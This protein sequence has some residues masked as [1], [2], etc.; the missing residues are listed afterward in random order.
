MR[1]PVRKKPARAIS[2]V[3]GSEIRMAGGGGSL[4]GVDMAAQ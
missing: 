2:Q 4:V 3:V 1:P